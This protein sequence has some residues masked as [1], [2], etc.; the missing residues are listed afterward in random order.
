MSNKEKILIT[1][2]LGYLGGR[3]AKYIAKNTDYYL[4]LGTRNKNTEKPA[5]LE[6]GEIVALDVLDD[7]LLKDACNDI[8]TIIHFAAIN[9]VDSLKDPE[10]ALKVNSLGSLKLLNTAINLGVKRIVYFSTAHVY[11]ALKGSINEKTI[12]RPSHPYSITHHVVEEFIQAA[13]DAKRIT[14]IVFRL[15]NALGAPE[16]ANVNRWT[17][18]VNDLCKQAVLHKK[19]VL[20]SSGE[21]RRD[22][23][24]IYDVARAVKHAILLPEKQ[25]GDGLFNLGGESP[26]RIFDIVNLLAS[27]CESILGFTPNIERPES[28]NISSPLLD[29]QIAKFKKTGFVLSG[30]IETEIDNTLMLCNETFG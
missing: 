18:I 22:F 8:T 19:L 30:S 7:A 21:Q 17:L 12:P 2:G 13:H 29:Y 27:R 24:T 1:G 28:S 4:V 14:G 25:C 23:I 9:E 20:K 6:N 11:G 15:S 26:L 3:V 16:R 5:W 10:L